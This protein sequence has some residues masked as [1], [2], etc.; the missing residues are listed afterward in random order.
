MSPSLVVSSYV[1]IT[2]CGVV[3]LLY[4]GLNPFQPR[5]WYN[6]AWRVIVA[7]V[8][9]CLLLLLLLGDSSALGIQSS[10]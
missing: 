6:R 9:S 8:A 7:G 1:G 2:A 5:R 3:Y 10:P 4:T